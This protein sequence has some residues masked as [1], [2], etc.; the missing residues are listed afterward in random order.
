METLLLAAIALLLFL[1]MSRLSKLTH[2][3]IPVLYLL[4]G[5][6]LGILLNS[7]G[8][9][10]LR[11]IFPGINTYNNLALLF[12]FFVA[13]FTINLPFLKK[14][15]S[16]TAKLF[17]L[18][19]YA[20][21]LVVALFIT[22]L[23]HFVSLPE[24][25]LHFLEALVVAGIFSVSSPA[26]VIP[27]CTDFIQ[28]GYRGKN[29]LPVTMISVSIIDS[30]ITVPII[31]VALFVLLAE[32]QGTSVGLWT[33]LGIILI[34]L[35]GIVI[36]LTLGLLLGRLEL[37]LVHILFL[38][39]NKKKQCFLYDYLLI[40]LAFGVA[41]LLT[42]LLDNLDI[43]KKAMTVFGILVM[44]G[45][46]IAINNRDTTGANV[47]IRTHGNKLFL[48]FGMPSIFLY[49][50]SLIDLSILF[51]PTLLLS[52]LAV[53]LIAIT[54]KGLTAKWILKEPVY[55]K[56]EQA[57]AALCFVPKG[58]ALIN[59]SIIFSALFGVH[60]ALISFM[61]MLAGVSML[62]TMT[63]GLSALKKSKGHFIRKTSDY[64]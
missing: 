43:L 50:G 5:I 54:T 51:R 64:L 24:G 48:M 62:L 17:S 4:S 35:L 38:K 46:G 14:T 28:S 45:M 23:F 53:T 41:L 60:S 61:M 6:L 47:I 44:C 1:I 7:F 29:N 11:S 33:L 8:I 9:E 55:T 25:P 37:F 21:T 31:F 3:E 52:L 22:L 34:I 56:G 15:G 10:S 58:V 49:V 2:I 19:A 63:L 18:P 30:F 59:F 32:G 42:L 20:E 12:M 40:L 26:N 13:G 39:L 27:V 57:F 36:A 16:I